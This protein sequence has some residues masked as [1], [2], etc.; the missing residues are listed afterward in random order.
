MINRETV[1]NGQSPYFGGVPT[2]PKARP[3]G[4]LAG[5]SSQAGL[6]VGKSV[7]ASPLLRPE[8]LAQWQENLGGGKGY[9]PYD[10]RRW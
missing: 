5:Q 7:K 1:V 8:I 3:G 10:P 2:T 6:E 4:T 9:S